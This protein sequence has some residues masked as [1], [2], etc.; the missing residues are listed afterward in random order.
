MRLAVTRV[1][2]VVKCLL[3]NITETAT[4]NTR[5]V[6]IKETESSPVQCVTAPLTSEIAFVSTFFTCT[7]NTALISVQCVANASP[8]HP[9]S[10]NTCEYTVV[11]DLTSVRIV[12]RPSLLLPF[13]GRTS[14]STV[15][16][17]PS[18][19]G[20]AS[21]HSHHM[22]RTTATCVARTQKR[23]HACVNT[24]ERRL[25]SHTNWSFISTCTREPNPTLVRNVAERFQVL[26]HVTDTAPILTALQERIE[27]LKSCERTC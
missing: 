14:V 24:V 20:T 6:L 25:R 2:A 22:P 17:S 1:N 9:V 16:K 13:Y 15:E 19:A 21:V 5:A 12:S 7:R 10:T 23:S 11:K 26:R 8:S 18:S 4:L 27:P 3:T